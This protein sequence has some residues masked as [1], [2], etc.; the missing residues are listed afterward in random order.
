MVANKGMRE[1][2]S[3]ICRYVRTCAIGRDKSEVEKYITNRELPHMRKEKKMAT[4]R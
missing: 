3:E 2:G 4:T 1:W